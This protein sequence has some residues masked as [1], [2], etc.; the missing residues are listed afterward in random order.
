MLL[1][2]FPRHPIAATLSLDA[3]DRV[4]GDGEGVASAPNSERV[5]NAAAA[6]LALD[7]RKL[8]LLIGFIASPFVFSRVPRRIIRRCSARFSGTA[9]PSRTDCP[10]LQSRARRHTAQYTRG[11][12]CPLHWRRCNE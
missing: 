5:V 7:C 8:R 3:A 4:V 9:H 11:G 1:S 2:P 6:A 12:T 10:M